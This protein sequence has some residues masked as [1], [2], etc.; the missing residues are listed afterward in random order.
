MMN[1]MPY[2]MENE[3]WFTYDQKTNTYTLTDKAP[4]KAIESY[5]EFIQYWGKPYN[6][7]GDMDKE[8]FD[9]FV[10]KELERLNNENKKKS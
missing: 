10:D 9:R 4:P 8:S 5:Q 3:E 6:W 2:F 7:F 1:E